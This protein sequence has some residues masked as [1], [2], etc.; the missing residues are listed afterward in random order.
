[1]PPGQLT[2][3]CPVGQVGQLVIQS[4][5][6][7]RAV[8]Y[9]GVRLALRRAAVRLERRGGG[10]VHGGYAVSLFEQLPVGRIGYEWKFGFGW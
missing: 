4:T 3:T 8:A 7:E 5:V 10:Y 6:V 9:V 2:I 1:M